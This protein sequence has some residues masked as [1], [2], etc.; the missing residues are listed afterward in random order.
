VGRARDYSEEETKQL[1]ENIIQIVSKEFNHPEMPIITN[2]D[3]GH[4]DPQFIL[5]LGIMAELD[6][7]M[8]V[9]RL[10]EKPLKD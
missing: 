4:T 2:M 7:K 8:K 10:V 1:E 6:C 3:F 5:P 9:F